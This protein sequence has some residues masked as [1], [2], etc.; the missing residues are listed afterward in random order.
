MAL[1]VAEFQGLLA[2]LADKLGVEVE[3]L[4][5]A[6]AGME[7]RDALALLSDAYPAIVTPYLAA[8]NDLSVVWYAEQP[9]RAGAAAFT[10]AAAPLAPVARL[11]ASARWAYFEDEA[12]TALQG[13]ATR[14]LF[15]QSRRTITANADSEGVRWARHASATACGFCRML[16]T[17]EAV[18]LSKETAS[19]AHDHCHCLAVPDR[20][21]R[22]EPAPYVAQWED[23]YAAAR[24]AGHTTP[25][26][27][28]N[29]MDHVEGG[30]RYTPPSPA[31]MPQTVAH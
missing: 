16:A 19:R 11:A 6:T 27:I 3:R 22:Y 17:R 24:E 30:R 21:G 10:P 13:S 9:V 7:Q 20:D 2:V 23:D 5:R 29:Y 1:A 25:E 4:I 14:A 12:V 28:A 15:G 8:A 26:A 31:D 18:Y